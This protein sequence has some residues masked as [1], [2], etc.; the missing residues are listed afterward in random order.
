MKLNK[1]IFGSVL[2]LGIAAA[3]TVHL[4]IPDSTWVGQTMLKGG[5]YDIKVNNDTVIFKLGNKEV[6]VN[7]KVEAGGVK[8][9]STTMEIRNQNGQTQLVE[10]DLGG[11]KSRIIFGDASGSQGGTH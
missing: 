9:P 11:T 5:N 3:T 8:Y 4:T 1:L 2:S 7:A 6:P 10:I